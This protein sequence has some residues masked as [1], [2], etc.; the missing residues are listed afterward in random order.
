[1]ETILLIENDPATLV[2]RSMVLRSFG[3]TVLEA[4]NQGEAW[5]AC[6][7]YQQPIHLTFLDHDNSSEFVTRLQILC[8]QIRAIFI[9]DEPSAELADMPASMPFFKNHSDWTPWPMRSG[10][11]ST[12]RRK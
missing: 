1:M 2:V 3:Y 7:E 6:N 5:F 9:S 4:A 12:D 10:N 8:P 11:C